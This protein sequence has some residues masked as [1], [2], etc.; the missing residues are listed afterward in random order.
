MSKVSYSLEIT[1][2]VDSQYDASRIEVAKVQTD[3]EILTRR[4][5]MGCPKF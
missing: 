4:Q 3:S 1:K 5:L 2:L